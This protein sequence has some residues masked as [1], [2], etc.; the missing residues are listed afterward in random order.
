MQDTFPD[1]RPLPED[2]EFLKLVWG[3]EDRCEAE[4]D[5][6]I[7]SMGVKAPQ[8]LDN[9]G[10]V[11]S[12]LDRATSCFWG[13]HGGEHTV[14]YLTGRVYSSARSSL[15]LLRFGFYDESLSLTRSIGEIANLLFL[16]FND[17]AAFSRWKASNKKERL[18]NFSPFKVRLALEGLGIPLPMD[19]ERYSQLCEIATHVTPETRPQAHNLVNQPV[20]GGY[21]QEAGVLVSLNELASAVAL[22]TFAAS[23]LMTLEEERRKYIGQAA[24]KLL[25]SVGAVD[26]I[27]MPQWWEKLRNSSDDPSSQPSA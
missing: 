20:L 3:Q 13:C 27:Q 26:V 23:K 9:L 4:T 21:F 18:A 15:R 22:A 24:L 14:E 2:I 16:F 10:A 6:R 7:P 1:G 5:Q 19:E 25:R 8:C 12:L 11:L 17:N